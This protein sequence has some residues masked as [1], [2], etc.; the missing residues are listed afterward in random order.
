MVFTSATILFW[1]FG[2]T[3]I[4]PWNDLTQDNRLSIT[5]EEKQMTEMSSTKL[6]TGEEEEEEEEENVRL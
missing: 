3:D 1:L 2:S 5:D 4:Q 6:Q